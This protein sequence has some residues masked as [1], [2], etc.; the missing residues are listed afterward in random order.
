MNIPENLRFTKEHEWARVEKGIATVG[1]S[2]YAQGELGDVVFVNLP[3]VGSKT[4]QMKACASIEAV[5]AVSDLYAPL[6]G[7]VMEVNEA[8]RTSPQLVN[9]DPYGEGWI[10]KIKVSNEKEI[11]NLMDAGAYKKLLG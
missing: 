4:E 3:S 2:E 6:S 9:K 7:E 10:L 8:L 11:A 1:I 5:K